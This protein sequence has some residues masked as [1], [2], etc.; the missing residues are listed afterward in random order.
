MKFVRQEGVLGG[1]DFCMPSAQPFFPRKQ[2][3][4]PTR[5][6]TDVAVATAN[7]LTPDGVAFHL[8][9]RLLPSPSFFGLNASNAAIVNI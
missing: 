1:A 8:N 4:C 7:A 2:N 5:L 9:G 6:R 3:V